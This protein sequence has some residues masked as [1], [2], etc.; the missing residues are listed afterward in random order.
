[1]VGPPMIL[2]VGA[3]C[4]RTRDCFHRPAIPATVESVQVVAG[5]G[6]DRSCDDDG[7]P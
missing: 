6:G 1:M 2:T 3:G 5:G 4:T 7:A